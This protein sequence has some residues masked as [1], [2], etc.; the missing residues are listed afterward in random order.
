MSEGNLSPRQKMINMMYLMLTAML[1][2]NV[3]KDVLNAFV[4]V[5]HGMKTTNHNTEEQNKKIYNRFEKEI[6]YNEAKVRPWKEKADKVHSKA[7][8]VFK[9]IQDLKI[10][11][12]EKGEGK[13]TEAID[14]EGIVH[15]ED[16]DGKDN[17]DIPAEIMVGA[18]NNGAGYELEKSIDN[19]REYLLSLFDNEKNS[20][21]TASIN[22]LLETP[23]PKHVKGHAGD[24]VTHH[25]EHMPL[26][27]V[28]TAMTGLQGNI[29]TAEYQMINYLYGQITAGEINF[30]KLEAVVI[31]NTNYVMQGAEYKARVFLAAMDTT[32]PPIVYVGDYDSTQNNGTWDYNMVGSY[33]SLEVDQGKGIFTKTAGALGEHTWEGIIKIVKGDGSTIERPFKES[34]RVSKPNAVVSATK[35]NV[36]YLGLDN[37][38]DISVPGVPKEDVQVSLTNGRIYRRGS[39]WVARPSR[40]GVNCQVRVYAEMQGERKFMGSQPFRVKTVPDPRP[41]VAGM[42]GGSITKSLL[43]AQEVVIA[44]LPNFLFDL[45]F[46][47]ESFNMY[48]VIGGFL[49]EEASTNNRITAR[50]KQLIQ[51][52]GRGNTI[53]FENIKARK[54]GGEVKDIGTISF[55]LK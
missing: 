21:L 41:V 9:E 31:P 10:K 1:A 25:F 49:Q 55:R 32:N 27:G 23:D 19:Y 35:M 12:V 26:I 16:I 43:A 15:G 28:I 40:A 8:E 24:W 37:P 38:V 3:S 30:N 48:T 13:D 46:S 18:N 45:K 51:K 44:E 17:T 33:D 47:V 36:F 2:M 54:P 6:Q 52:A 34:Y 50:Q 7:N 14:K 11:I 29:R 42:P 5:N 53:T 39:A 22:E 20:Y 4:L